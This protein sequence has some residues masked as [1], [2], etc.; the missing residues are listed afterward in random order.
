MSVRRAAKLLSG[1]AP[2]FMVSLSALGERLK[3]AAITGNRSAGTIV[4]GHSCSSGICYMGR[5]KPVQMTAV[6]GGARDLAAYFGARF[7]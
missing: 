7:V 5:R 2:D 3:P 4:S 6:V 1:C